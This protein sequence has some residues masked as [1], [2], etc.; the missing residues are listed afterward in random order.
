V[1]ATESDRMVETMERV[2]DL[3]RVLAF[4]G[5]RF[6]GNGWPTQNIHTSEGVAHATGIS[7]LVISGH[8][9]ESYIVG[10]LT[11]VVGMAWWGGGS[12]DIKLIRPV[13]TKEVLDLRM[14]YH[15][16]GSGKL[17][18]DIEVGSPQRGVASTAHA[19]VS[20]NA[21]EVLSTMSVPEAVDD[22]PSER[23]DVTQQRVGDR[24][25][26]YYFTVDKPLNDQYLF[27]LEDYDPMYTGGVGNGRPAMVHPGV[28]LSSSNIS[29]SPSYFSPPGTHAMFSRDL[30]TFLSPAN[31]GEELRMDCTV[32]DVFEKRG[33]SWFVTEA[34][35]R[36]SDGRVSIR[37]L[38]AAAL[39]TQ[40][41]PMG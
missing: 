13:F 2:V 18:G 10:L 7:E 34:L 30:I 21:Q 19:E 31:I 33:R 29:R 23:I 27:A 14:T 1:E 37:R 6:S 15:H 40:S 25:K 8:Q 39:Q 5:G 38:T 22:P 24:Y 17:V 36:G 16:D 28:L 9:V 20:R 26:P 12:L 3:E 11:K 32:T 41:T 35:I 4:S